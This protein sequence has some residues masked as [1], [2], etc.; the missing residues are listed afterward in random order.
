[1]R[2]PS[3]RPHPLGSRGSGFV[4]GAELVEQLQARWPT[5]VG[6]LILSFGDIE[7]AVP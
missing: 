6:K 4:E 1:M 3:R 2:R 7:W 5:A